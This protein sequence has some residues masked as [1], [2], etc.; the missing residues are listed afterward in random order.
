[1][2]SGG[3][4]GRRLDPGRR[5]CRGGQGRAMADGRG[6]EGPIADGRGRGARPRGWES[7][8]GLASRDSRRLDLSG[9]WGIGQSTQ[10]AEGRGRGEL[11]ACDGLLSCGLGWAWLL[12][13]LLIS[14]WLDSARELLASQLELAR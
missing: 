2:L 14:L 13:R 8:W 9:R 5:R 1:M 4:S 3:G 10:A 6:G 11:R 12:G 7:G